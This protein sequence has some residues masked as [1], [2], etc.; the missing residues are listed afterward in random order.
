MVSADLVW[1]KKNMIP[2]GRSITFK[3]SLLV[4]GSTCLVLAVV[5]YLMYTSSRELIR[6]EAETS[7]QNLVSS[8]SNQIEQEFL[9]VA[10]AADQFSSFLEYCSNTN[11]CKLVIA[12]PFNIVNCAKSIILSLKRRLK[13]E[14]VQTEIVNPLFY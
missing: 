13:C 9:V 3:I 7:A 1:E 14:K 5:V 4:L 10:E 6:L 8:L 11:E 12:V 2:L